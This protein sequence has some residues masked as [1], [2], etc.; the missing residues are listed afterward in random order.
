MK[1]VVF[2]CLSLIFLTLKLEA[3]HLPGPPKLKHPSLPSGHYFHPP[4]YDPV[5][6]QEIVN[7]VMNVIEH[8]KQINDPNVGIVDF[9]DTVN[10][11]MAK[12]FPSLYFFISHNFP[13][14]L[15]TI[16]QIKPMLI[17]IPLHQKFIMMKKR[18]INMM[19]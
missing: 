4:I 16:T 1:Q 8:F 15:L 2:Y 3:Q 18:K 10:R 14:N 7:D 17:I 5:T 19:T 6:H 13:K 11:Q 12:P 9:N